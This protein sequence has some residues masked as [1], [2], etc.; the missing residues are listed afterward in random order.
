MALYDSF[1]EELYND[2]KQSCETYKLSLSINWQYCNFSDIC[3]NDYIYVEYCPSSLKHIFTH[4][5][6]CGKVLKIENVYCE[7]NNN[8]YKNII[9]K[10]HMDQ[11]ISI[12]K[13]W[14]CDYSDGYDM[15][16]LK[17]T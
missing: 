1:Q 9:I 8:I 7:V 16:I 14:L 17:K 3:V 10:N 11:E 4:T 15:Y 2:Y 12:I 5:P 6:E 13:E